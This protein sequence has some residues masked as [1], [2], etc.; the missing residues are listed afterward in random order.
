MWNRALPVDGGTYTITVRAPGANAWSTEITVG[1]EADRRTLEIPDLRNLPRDL[2]PSV[3]VT[4]TPTTVVAPSVPASAPVPP[5]PD[6]HGSSFLP[7]AVG[8]SAV[9]LLVGALGM[10]LWGD[11]TYDRAR[12]EML[13]QARRD[14]LYDAANTKRHVTAGFAAA[15][16]ATAGAAVWL[17]LGQRNENPAVIAR[18]RQVIVSPIGI[19][20]MGA[21]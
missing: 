12:A 17:Y 7:L 1:A 9:V 13:D 2:I 19:A 14:S 18:R 5:L 15:G 20:V 8:G 11:S 16:V 3:P 21:F 10:K 4:P 6:G